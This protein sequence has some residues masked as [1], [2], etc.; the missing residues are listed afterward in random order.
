MARAAERNQIRRIIVAAD[1]PPFAM[2]NRQIKR[3]AAPRTRAA[4][5][6]DDGL[7]KVLPGLRRIN[8][9]TIADRLSRSDGSTRRRAESCLSN[10]R[11]NDFALGF[12]D[13]TSNRHASPRTF[14][15]AG[16][17]V[18]AVFSSATTGLDVGKQLSTSRAR[19]RCSAGGRTAS[20]GAKKPARPFVSKRCEKFERLPAVTAQANFPSGTHGHNSIARCDAGGR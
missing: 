3:R 8:V 10:E 12:A 1:F 14:R 20:Y 2:M 11:R 6:V 9:V 16:A 13:L 17:G 15:Y 19:V 4:V 5:A 18:R 7:S